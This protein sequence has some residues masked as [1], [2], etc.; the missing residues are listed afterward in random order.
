MKGFSTF[1][2]ISRA[3]YYTV[4]SSIAPD[5]LAAVNPVTIFPLSAFNWWH[6]S[7]IHLT[8]KGFIN[9]RRRKTFTSWSY[10]FLSCFEISFV[11]QV[12]YFLEMYAFAT[13]L[14][15]R[16]SGGNL[17][18]KLCGMI[19]MSQLFLAQSSLKSS[20]CL[21]NVSIITS[22]ICSF[23]YALFSLIWSKY[24]KMVVF[25]VRA[26]ETK[27]KFNIWQTSCGFSGVYFF[28]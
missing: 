18:G 19:T 15:L 21:L 3:F 11:K 7:T 14:M 24:G 4:V 16:S 27:R 5:I 1:S 28:A 17:L 6:K 26:V 10:A 23:G 22:D 2:V 12:F 25:G 13:L 20:F 8:F 9:K